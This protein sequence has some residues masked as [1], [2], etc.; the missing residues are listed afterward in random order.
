MKTYKSHKT[1]EAAKI[2]EA[3][4]LVETGA[5]VLLLEGYGTTTVAAEWVRKHAPPSEALGSLVGGYFVRYADGYTSWSPAQAF[6]EGYSEVDGAAPEVDVEVRPLVGAEATREAALRAALS[7]H[8][9]AP[10][11]YADVITTA[12]A[13]AGFLAG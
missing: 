6:E 2:L 12:R 10:A 5:A 1:V 3:N 7:L 11:S 13:F 9:G 4:A 8:V